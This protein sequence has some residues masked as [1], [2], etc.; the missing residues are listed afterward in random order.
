MHRHRAHE[1]LAVEVDAGHEARAALHRARRRQHLEDFL[2]HDEL[3]LR[4]LQVDD[5]RGARDG[6]RLFERADLE[7]GV[8]R[9]GEVAL[10]HDAF[11]ANGSEAGQREGDGVGARP[12]ADDREAPRAV[13]DRP[14]GR[15]RS[16]HR[17][18]ASTVTPGITA[19]E[20]S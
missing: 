17:L 14:T 18:M 16:A 13:G 3:I 20:V 12:Q 19:P 6:D 7:V 8:H 4:A 9:R 5:R 2:V 10:Q 11:A 1:A 15:A